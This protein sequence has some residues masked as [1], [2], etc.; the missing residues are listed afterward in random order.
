[1]IHCYGLFHPTGTNVHASLEESVRFR[2]P[3]GTERAAVFLSH[4]KKIYE[5]NLS[6]GRNYFPSHFVLITVCNDHKN[7]PFFTSWSGNKTQSVLFAKLMVSDE[8][9]FL[10]ACKPNKILQICT[11]LFMV[12]TYTQR[13]YIHNFCGLQSMNSIWRAV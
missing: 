3:G 1:M 12:G 7:L 4:S 6:I 13:L 10:A 9:R 8:L 5:N 2:I 11:V